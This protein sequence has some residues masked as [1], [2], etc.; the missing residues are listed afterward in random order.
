MVVFL[1]NEPHPRLRP[2][3]QP[4]PRRRLLPSSGPLHFGANQP[5]HYGVGPRGDTQGAETEVAC[6]THRCQ[7]GVVEQLR[8]GGAG[9][10]PLIYAQQMADVQR[11]IGTATEQAP[12]VVSLKDPSD[13]AWL[14]VSLGQWPPSEDGGPSRF[15][16][17]YIEAARSEHTSQCPDR[18]SPPARPRL[19]CTPDRAGGLYGGGPSAPTAPA[20]GRSTTVPL[21]A[22]APHARPLVARRLRQKG[23]GSSDPSSTRVAR[24]GTGRAPTLDGLNTLMRVAN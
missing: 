12:T 20:C 1:L 17:R 16:G 21:R 6:L 5:Q 24:P 7:V 14:D 11:L 2:P 19:R 23:A 18:P 9:S 4:T 10:E 3:C 13:L 22:E 15:S 8:L